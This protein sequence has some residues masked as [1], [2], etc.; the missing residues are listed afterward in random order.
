MNPANAVKFSTKAGAPA[1][2]AFI[3]E[4]GKATA[5]GAVGGLIYKV[6][7]KD[8]TTASIEEYYRENPPK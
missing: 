6:V 4:A 5:I 2:Q 3:R 1:L 8:P 7:I